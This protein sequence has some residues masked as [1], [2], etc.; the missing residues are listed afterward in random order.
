MSRPGTNCNRKDGN[1]LILF[2]AKKN[3]I[4]K[5]S[6]ILKNVSKVLRFS[7]EKK[8]KKF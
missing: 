1:R 7:I 4:A 2:K 5:V 6:L 8:I 3:L